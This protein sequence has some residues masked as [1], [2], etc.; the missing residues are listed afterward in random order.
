MDLG[1]PFSRTRCALVWG[2]TT[3]FAVLLVGWLLRPGASPGS[4]FESALVRVC[5]LVATAVT[6]WLWV[7]ATLVAADVARGR[8]GPRRG[9]PESVRR[10]V[11]VLCGVAVTAGLASPVLA[12]G[13]SAPDP[14]VLAGLRLPERIAVGAVAQAARPG[15]PP[16]ALEHVVV[17]PGD[18]LWSIT[19]R[20]LGPGATADEVARAWP[21][22]YAANRDVVGPD[23]GLLEPGQRL[24]VPRE[25]ASR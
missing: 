19:E 1:T 7:G 3:A 10:G 14:G 4:G 18:S 22:L 23:P 20:R 25:E 17:R 11:L 15:P 24:V 2:L 8:R 13:G 6:V 16:P 12:A 21:V 9:V 5:A